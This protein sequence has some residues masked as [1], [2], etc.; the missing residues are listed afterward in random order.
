MEIIKEIYHYYLYLRKKFCFFIKYIIN[1]RKSKNYILNIKEDN[2]FITNDHGGGTLVF[3]N[4]YLKDKKYLILRFIVDDYFKD[5]GLILEN[6]NTK[7]YYKINKIEE[8][9]NRSYNNIFIN[10][11]KSLDIINVVIDNIISNKKKN[12]A[13]QIIYYVHDFHSICPNCNLFKDGKFCNLQCLNRNCNIF[14]K[15]RN[16]KIND[17][18]QKWFDLFSNLDHIVCMS[19]SSRK[20]MIKAFGRKIDEKII[21][22]PHDMSYCKFEPINYD[23]KSLNIAIVGTTFAP[24]KGKKIVEDIIEQFGNTVHIDIMGAPKNK[25]R[26]RGKLVTFK[27]RYKKEDL[28]EL[29]KAKKTNLVVFPSLCPETFSY[30]VSEIMILNLP[31]ICFNIGAQ[32]E[33]VSKYSKG[34]VVSTKEEMYN[35]IENKRKELNS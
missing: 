7:Y 10:T 5:I 6:K 25:F 13:S 16:I 29:L 11:L 17:W 30:V 34:T 14:E 12:E 1:Y 21:V 33:K 32:A 19:Q 31:I 22:K 26:S 28:M 8:I 9:L 3:E 2:I 4:N 23:E 35:F 15:K 27:K 20:L 24:Y 18:R